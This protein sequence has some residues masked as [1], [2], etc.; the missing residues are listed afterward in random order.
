MARGREAES[1]AVAQ[2]P[3]TLWR[4]GAHPETLNRSAQ[5]WR[6]IAS[7]IDATRAEVAAA[8]AALLAV[9]SGE[10]SDC[11][12]AHQHN[13]A[14]ALADIA[15]TT[16][17]IGT[18]VEGTAA[19][20][21]RAQAGLDSSWDRLQH[22]PTT[23]TVAV[24][25]ATARAI[26]ADATTELTAIA[27]SLATLR[28][29]FWPYHVSADM[30]EPADAPWS[31]GNV[32]LAGIPRVIDDGRRVVV[33]GTTAGDAIVV[34][35]Y[36]DGRQWV[37]VNHVRYMFPADTQIVVC[38]GD[39]NDTVRVMSDFGVT[40]LGGR[41]KDTIAGGDG[42][43]V[44]LGLWDDDVI[45]A[46]GGRDVVFGGAQTDYISGG[47]GDDLLDGG[48][49]ADI[50]YGLTGADSI[51]GSADRDYLD[52]GAGDDQVN[53]GQ[54][55]DVIF[56]GR[57]TDRLTG[58]FGDD[59]LAGGE[60]TDTVCGDDGTDTLYRQVDDRGLAES[61]VTMTQIS[62]GGLAIDAA[63][64]EFRARVESDLEALRSVPAGQE[65]LRL[66]DEAHTE[67]GDTLVVEE[68]SG[69]DFET[70]EP[71]DGAPVGARVYYNPTYT[72]PGFDG[73]P[74]IPLTHLFHELGHAY[75]DMY[76]SAAA[77]TYCGPDDFGVSNLERAVVGLPI[78]HDGKPSTPNLLDP[79]HPYAIT[80]NA[81]RVQ[82]GLPRR[83]RYLQ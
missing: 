29:R 47:A 39:G 19:V 48:S 8:S 33:S 61:V 37:S 78:D 49:G 12:R 71:R 60:G 77:G 53:G 83:K 62:T 32:D 16:G 46:H 4:L 81:L 69:G 14:G 44:I 26:R 25:T 58:G 18:A 10:A 54:Q 7:E 45:T 82:L 59:M 51:W 3:S 42:D 79:E 6:D 35:R 31:L 27:A 52:G 41:G 17:A 15:A 13:R 36:P 66:L 5:A 40:V 20:M 65:M 9:W 75:D 1:D 2:P 68:T 73:L 55:D 22:D 80:E 50:V 74:N 38:G 43:D 34:G 23:A 64:A 30:N 57:G 70:G 63:T 28:R 72:A 21:R 76:D 56:G 11:Y 24:E 67:H